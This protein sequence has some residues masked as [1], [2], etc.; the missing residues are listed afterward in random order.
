[1][2]ELV[3]MIERFLSELERANLADVPQELMTVMG[4]VKSQLENV[5]AEIE[6]AFKN[7][8]G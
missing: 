5:S 6:S 1:M 7:P 3:N 2:D 4:H 8:I